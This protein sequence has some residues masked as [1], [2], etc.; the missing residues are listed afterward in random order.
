MSGPENNEKK[1][2]LEQLLQLKRTERP[3]SEFW[4]EFDREL[5]RRQLAALVTVRPWY[6]RSFDFALRLARRAALPATAT[7]GAAAVYVVF[8][9]TPSAPTPTAEPALPIQ[10]A[11]AEVESEPRAL[12]L[13]E[14]YFSPTST[15]I[16]E[17]A[18]RLPPVRMPVTESRYVVQDFSAT[19]S[20]SQTFVTQALPQTLSAVGVD[21]GAVHMH[22]LT[23]SPVR[24][25]AAAIS[26]SF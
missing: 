9:R 6:A 21:S 4:D 1:I 24:R 22:S 11:S 23:A 25:A 18:E 19:I 17:R 16:E 8:G 26:D 7:L 13:P 10:V 3:A 2:T 14:E 12:L 5:H 15:S 20:T